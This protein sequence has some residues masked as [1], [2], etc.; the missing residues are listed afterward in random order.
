MESLSSFERIKTVLQLQEPDRIPTF[1]WSIN[2][3]VR[4]GLFPGSSDFD[5]AE[6][7]NLD[8]VVVYADYIL[9]RL[10]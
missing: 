10:E 6:K 4:N 9:A 8:G 3:K 5:F 7:A 2:E 1:E